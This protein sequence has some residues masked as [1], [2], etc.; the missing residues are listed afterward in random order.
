MVA[1]RAVRRERYWS[2]RGG[3][4]AG[5]G[6]ADGGFIG[7]LQQAIARI[8]PW[9]STSAND[10][11]QAVKKGEAVSLS[12]VLPKVRASYPG[13]VLEVDL[14]RHASGEWRYELLVLGSDGLYREIIVDARR[15]RILQSE[16]TIMR[17]LVVE[18]EKRIATDIAESLNNAGYVTEQVHDGEEAWFRAETEEFDAIILDLG[19][20]KIDGLSVLRK[21]RGEAV[22][23]PI[24]ILTARSSWMERVE[25]IDAGGD[26]YLSKPFQS[27]ELVARVGALIRRAGG[28]FTPTLTYGDINIDTRRKNVFVNGR[29][30]DLSPL[31]FRLLRYLVH[32]QGRVVS[33]G[34][35][36]DHVYG[37][38]REPDSNAIEVLVGR[39]R[40]KVG[41][42]HNRDTAR[43]WLY[44]RGQ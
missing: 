31:E 3:H 37:S 1:V 5:R 7:G 24:L 23:T 4:A 41:S 28:H 30:I 35:L 38:E 2:G 15:N 32:H 40:R 26:D 18:D 21:L 29:S 39:V 19:L 44:D 33:Q 34:E 14:R 16:E 11:R 25:G 27:E 20:P 36:V 6:G 22:A 10:A 9:G 12:A 8:T 17:V 43:A 13:D 42:T